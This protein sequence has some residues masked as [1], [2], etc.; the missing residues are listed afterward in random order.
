MVTEWSRSLA[1]LRG[2]T[3]TR[4][5]PP[6]RTRERLLG[7]QS[8]N[9]GL[10]QADIVAGLKR[11]GVAAVILLIGMLLALALVVSDRVLKWAIALEMD[12]NSSS[13]KIIDAAI[14]YFLV[15]SAVVVA[16]CG[17]LTV[18]GEGVFTLFWYFKRW[19]PL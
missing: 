11:F 4:Q 18:A 8:P 7:E 14:N 3:E 2:G 10:G 12:V 5:T 13:F 1:A 16:A 17:A 15:G 9:K 19:R 6:G